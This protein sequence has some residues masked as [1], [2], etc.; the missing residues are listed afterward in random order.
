[1]DSARRYKSYA[2]LLLGRVPF[3][4][5]YAEPP[6]AAASA[7]CVRA[8]IFSRSSIMLRTGA[9]NV[10]AHNTRPLFTSMASS[11]RCNRSPSPTKR[12]VTMLAAFI[13]APALRRS[14]PG[15]A[16]C[17]LVKNGCTESPPS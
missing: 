15:R 11:V 10:S 6:S 8:A 14:R 17:E 16:Y 7:P 2:S 12:P 13:S 9:S 4:T 1:M 5:V 3:V